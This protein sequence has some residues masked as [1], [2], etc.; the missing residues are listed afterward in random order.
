MPSKI[1]A[2][3]GLRGM[4]GFSEVKWKVKLSQA[5][6]FLCRVLGVAPAPAGRRHEFRIGLKP[7]SHG[8]QDQCP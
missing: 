7:S 6:A 4:N 5:S 8:T 2:D 3:L 1:I